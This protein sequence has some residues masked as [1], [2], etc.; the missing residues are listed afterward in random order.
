MSRFINNL[1][2][3]VSKDLKKI[4]LP[5]SNSRRVLQAAERVQA[6][7]FARPILVGKPQELVEV[8]SE[9]QIDLDGIE[10]IDP[11]TYP[12]IDEFSTYYAQRRE[13]RGMTVEQARQI[14]LNNNNFFG[15]CLVAF[16]IADGMVAGAVATSSEVIRAALQVIG[17]HPGTSTVSSSFIVITDKP[18]FG[19]DGIFV[20][21]D[22]SVVIEPT[23]QQLA[24]IA[25]SCVERAR[26]TVQTLDPKV[27]LLSY[28]TMG[29]GNGGEV[30]R[31]REAV[32]LLRDRNVD[33]EFDGELQADAALV[34]RIARQKA[35]GSPVAG[36]A[37]ILVF[38][39]LV[40]GNIC[41]KMLQHLSGATALGPLLQGLAKP[42]M[43]LSRGCTPED[44]TDVIAICCSDAIYMEA[45]RERDIAFTSRFEKL[46]RRVAVENQNVSIQFDSEKCKN[47]TLCRRRC[48]DVMS[49]TGYYSL[50]STGDKP[51]CVHCGQCSLTCMF[52]ATTTV[53]QRE[54]IQQ[55]ID[56]PEKVVIFQTAPAV[57]VAL[58]DS[59]GMPYGA[60]V[61]G[62]MV[63]A[64]R[65]LGGDYIFD[66]DFGADL[67]I[68]EEASEL[69][70]R[71]KNKRELLPQFTSCCPSWVEFTEIF[72]PELIPHLSTA[73]S[74]ISMLSPMI[75]TYFAKRMQIDPAKIVT[76]CVTPCTSKKAEIARPERNAAG[77][78]WK[79]P[80]IRDTDYCITTR[81][82]AQ[83]ITDRNIDFAALSESEFDS[84]FGESSGA[85]TIF[86]NS[87][88][89]MEAALRTL[90]YLRTGQVA[91]REFLRFEPVRGLE[92]VKEAAITLDNDIIHVVAISGL[93]NARKFI[94]RMEEKHSWKKYAFIE[95]MACPGGCI[96]GGGQPRTKL[97]QEIPA[98]RARIESLYAMDKE[99]PIHA[100]WENREVQ[101][102]YAKFLGEPC[103]ELSEQLLHTQYVNKHYMLGKE[104]K[105]VPP[106]KPERKP[107]A[108]IKK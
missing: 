32:N 31:V 71:I 98:K 90:M 75:K 37:N 57:R 36:Q 15:A 25:V 64:L 69:L 56:D 103:S 20:L 44:I 78:Y 42:V 86:G 13:K 29:S 19:D 73:K 74:P 105:V 45:E 27:A 55:A 54:L 7:G 59:F 22:A 43:D 66:T 6:E 104:D 62:K 96:G 82:L 21:G 53:S 41:Y 85:G 8:A 100:S 14:L 35:P 80:E 81:E 40:S 101:T 24:D 2:R 60:I 50:E 33:F 1:K 94:N 91:D 107:A 76:V 28:S 79:K 99:N 26:R 39:N 58:G 9:C 18:Q 93:G 10:I 65:Q 108:V 5:E 87:G 30:D 3:R 11:K 49:M 47:C 38:P 95:V 34:P 97:P 23:A 4:V 72:F 102:L 84:V 46:D 61:R 92:G 16:D 51:I 12:M 106:P 17:T 70:Y 83:W 68:M 67:T 77:I 88:G 52:G 89:V 48:A 63:S